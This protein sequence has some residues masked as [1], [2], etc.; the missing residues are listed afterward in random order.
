MS[1]ATLEDVKRY[2]PEVVD[3]ASLQPHLDAAEE[4]VSRVS[5]AD[6]DSTAEIT[7]TFYNVCDGAIVTLREETPS[8]LSVKAYLAH[9]STGATLVEDSGYHLR[10]RG[11]VELLWSRYGSP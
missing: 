4:W 11:R 8:D 5:G 6:F 9:G 2:V 10:T 7:E 3:D 1:I